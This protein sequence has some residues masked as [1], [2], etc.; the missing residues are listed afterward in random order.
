MILPTSVHGVTLA[1]TGGM[2]FAVSSIVFYSF[3]VDYILLSLFRY[4]AG[5]TEFPT[6]V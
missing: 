6:P 4:V 2:L 3:R 1:G 5:S